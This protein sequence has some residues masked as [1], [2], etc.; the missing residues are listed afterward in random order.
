MGARVKLKKLKSEVKRATESQ[1]WFHEMAFDSMGVVASMGG[2][3]EADEA[4][5][6]YESACER[7]G[8]EPRAKNW[9]SDWDELHG[10]EP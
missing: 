10:V 2:T 1:E 6:Q 3:L 8:M 7:F 9:E 5:E 4:Y